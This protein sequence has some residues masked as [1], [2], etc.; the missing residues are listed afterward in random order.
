MA[1]RWEWTDKIGEV[2]N[3]RGYV[4]NIYRG[5]AFMIAVHEWKEEE[6]ELYALQWFFADKEHLHNCLGLNKGYEGIDFDWAE[7]KLNYRYKE[8][9]QFIE[10]L[11]K[12]KMSMKITLYWEE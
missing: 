2:K 8:T 5:N 12:A 10:A 6:E 1:L 9:R 4:H 7:F 3:T 11:A